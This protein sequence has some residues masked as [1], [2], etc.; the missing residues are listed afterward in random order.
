MTIYE[1]TVIIWEHFGD[2]CRR[3]AQKNFGYTRNFLAQKLPQ[4][5]SQLQTHETHQRKD[6]CKKVYGIWGKFEYVLKYFEIYVSNF[7]KLP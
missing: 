7:L 2:I 1:I 3:S 6:R 5:R 4:G